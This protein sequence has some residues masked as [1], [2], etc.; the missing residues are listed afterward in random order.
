MAQHASSVDGFSMTG[1]AMVTPV[2]V[3]TQE[4][5]GMNGTSNGIGG[6]ADEALGPPPSSLLK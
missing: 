3:K 1:L 4:S 6:D 2:V 5:I